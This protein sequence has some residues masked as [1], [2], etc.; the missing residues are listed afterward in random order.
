MQ[1]MDSIE[2]ESLSENMIIANSSEEVKVL[3]KFVPNEMYANHKRLIILEFVASWCGLCQKVSPQM[4]EIAEIFGGK[5]I[6][7][8]LVISPRQK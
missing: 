4:E 6:T 1:K 2:Q 7:T 5:S 8:G 3:L